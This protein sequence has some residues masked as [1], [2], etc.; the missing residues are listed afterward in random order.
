MNTQLILASNDRK[1]SVIKM[2]MKFDKEYRDIE[3]LID[4]CTA[5]DENA[6]TDRECREYFASDDFDNHDCHLSPQDGCEVCEKHF[7]EVEA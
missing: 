7:R 2:S 1:I 3:T 6:E 5:L 4:I